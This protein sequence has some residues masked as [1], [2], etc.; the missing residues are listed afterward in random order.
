MREINGIKYFTVGFI[1]FTT[2]TA[3]ISAET[4]EVG[5]GMTSLGVTVEGSFEASD[6]LSY[7]GLY[8]L[9]LNRSFDE[10]QDGVDY[11][12]EGELD[13][14]ALLAD[15]KPFGGGFVAGGGLFS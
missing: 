10:T 4:F 1:A 3:P 6:K 13:G 12:I 9:G 8:F 2:S 5:L 15:Y 14:F 11:N 7:L